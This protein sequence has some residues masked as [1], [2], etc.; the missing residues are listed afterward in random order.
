MVIDRP[1]SD[2]GQLVL[3]GAISLAF[4]L[5]GVVIVFNSVQYTETIDSGGANDDISEIRTIESEIQTNLE[6][7]SEEQSVDDSDVE[8]YIDENYAPQK[9]AEGPIHISYVQSSYSV[10]SPDTFKI[11]ITTTELT[12]TKEIEVDA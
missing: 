5:L 1:T 8:E 10:G 11:N 7:L 3:I 4:I 2:R 6:T 9:A 12:V